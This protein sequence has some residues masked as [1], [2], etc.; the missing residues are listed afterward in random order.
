M[1]PALALLFIFL[2][3]CTSSGPTTYSSDPVR[4]DVHA[5][6]DVAD[7]SSDVGLDVGQ[8]GD[9][10]GE[11]SEAQ[12]APPDATTCVAGTQDCDGDHLQQCLWGAWTVV[13]PACPEGCTD[14]RCNACRP[15]QKRCKDTTIEVCAADGSGWQQ[16]ADCPGCG[17]CLDGA[18]VDAC[19]GKAC[20]DNR[21][22]DSC[23]ECEAGHTC[24]DGACC[25]QNCDGKICGDDGCGGNCGHCVGSKSKCYEAECYIPCGLGPVTNPCIDAHTVGTCIKDLGIM[26]PAGN[27]PGGCDASGCHQ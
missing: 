6:T 2:V 20:G 5:G 16:L 12:D 4:G 23:G 3:A 10:P 24:K 1:K 8:L 27:C 14:G 25:I 19:T 11:V 26:V 13:D 18:C 21:C 15:G 22:G 7:V 17:G 9:A